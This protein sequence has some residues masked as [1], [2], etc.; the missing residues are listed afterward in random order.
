MF[1]FND[2]LN[3]Q[4]N[5]YACKCRDRAVESIEE[6]LPPRKAYLLVERSERFIGELVGRIEMKLG[7]EP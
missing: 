5:S 1:F 2:V 6:L 4:I 3:Q 7:F